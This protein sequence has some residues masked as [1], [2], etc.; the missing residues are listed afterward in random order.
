MPYIQLI[1]SHRTTREDKCMKNNA[2]SQKN[3]SMSDYSLIKVT[4]PV[5]RSPEENHPEIT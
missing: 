3:Q 2:Q 1:N 4:K 5:S